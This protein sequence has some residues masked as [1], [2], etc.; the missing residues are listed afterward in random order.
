M[1]ITSFTAVLRKLKD[2]DSNNLTFLLLDTVVS[3]MLLCFYGK[4]LLI[5]PAD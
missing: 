5:N 3:P 2:I 1:G 4:M